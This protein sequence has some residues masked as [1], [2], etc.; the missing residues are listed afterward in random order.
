MGLYENDG[1]PLFIP[2]PPWESVY[3]REDKLLFQETTLKVRKK[4]RK[5]AF[6]ANEL[7]IEAENYIGLE[8]DFMYHLNN[9]LLKMAGGR[10]NLI[11]RE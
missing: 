10:N 2:A 1:R 3:V 4:Y 6:T 11:R 7:H 9:L 5:Y 8:L